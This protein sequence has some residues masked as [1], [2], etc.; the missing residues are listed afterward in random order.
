MAVLS[1][2]RV[3]TR[4]YA[5]FGTTLAVL[6]AVGGLGWWSLNGLQQQFVGA[7]EFAAD[8]ALVGDLRG[9]VIAVNDAIETWTQDRS[10]ENRA[11][12]TAAI[13]ATDA[14]LAA[15][16]E[17]LQNPERARLAA[18]ASAG[19]ESYKEGFARFETLWAERD[20]IVAEMDQRGP[21]MYAAIVE[22]HGELKSAGNFEGAA[23]AALVKDS[24]QTGRL[25]TQR[26]LRTNDAVEAEK[27]AAEFAQAQRDLDALQRFL[28][29]SPAQRP[30]LL[31]ETFRF[32]GEASRRLED[33]ISERN[34]IRAEALQAG[35]AAVV[36]TAERILESVSRDPVALSDA[37]LA[38]AAEAKTLA[39]LAALMA[40]A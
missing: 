38:G 25:A 26:Y 22:V 39:L 1:S 30:I 5:G 8:V 10:D 21:A 32:Y 27:A 31:P 6:A 34:T 17:Q 12:V 2:L 9:D 15:A 4:I 7:T 20:R 23:T 37:A 14:A 28:G 11:R 19:F 33:I 35:G 3:S 40:L 24:V 36:A 13:A 29:A 18:E 16:R